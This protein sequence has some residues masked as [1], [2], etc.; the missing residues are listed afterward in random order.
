MSILMY[1]QRHR[2][3]NYRKT[4]K[5]NYAHIGY[6]ATRPGASKNEGMRHGLFGKLTPDGEITEFQTWQEVGRLVREMSYRNVNIFRG[7]ISFTAETAAELDLTDHRAWEDYIEQHISTLARKNGI[8]V[9]DLQWAAAHHN[10]R[11]HPHIHVVF[12]NKNQQTMIP[13][14]NPKVPDSIRIQLIKDT[15]HDK[16]QAFLAEKDI[17][18]AG[19][20]ALTDEAVSAFDKYMKKLRPEEYRRLKEQ[21]GRIDDDELGAPPVSGLV[22]KSSLAALMPQLFALKEKMPNKGRL[23]YKLLP[24]DLKTELDAFVSDLKEQNEY[25]RHLVDDYADSKSRLAMLYDTDP[26]NL[27]AHRSKAVDEADK[28][29]ANKVLAVIKSMLNKEKELSAFE[30]SEAQKAY[31]TEE[32]ICEILMML[33]QAVMA[34]DEDY[35]AKEK[36]MTADLSK[37]AKKEWYLRHKDRGLDI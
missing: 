8:R 24:E 18:K 27:S 25:I 19:L 3:T 21:F 16:I 32:V 28:I 34:L 14:V 10:E 2:P 20:Y 15:F 5:C 35:D 31:Y 17:A 29:I 33:E 30:Y 37:A 13:F 9:Q 22:D 4:P 1:K 36:A 7:I 23:L 26:D 6:I 11:S 12:W